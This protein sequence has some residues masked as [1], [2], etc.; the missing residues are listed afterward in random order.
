[1]SR[2]I[3]RCLL[4]MQSKPQSVII[5]TEKIPKLRKA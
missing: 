1:Q 2:S 4:K 5:K 3:V